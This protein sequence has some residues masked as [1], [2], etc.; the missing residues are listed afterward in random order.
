M[1]RSIANMVSKRNFSVINEFTY[2]QVA[3][4]KDP[5]PHEIAESEEEAL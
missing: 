4:E 5:K 3:V 2:K 1:I